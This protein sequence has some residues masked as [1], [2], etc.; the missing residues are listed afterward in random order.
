MDFMAKKKN[1]SK[2]NSDADE[3]WIEKGE[4]KGSRG[5]RATM[6]MIK[7]GPCTTKLRCVVLGMK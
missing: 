3:Q 2:N 4:W 6:K 1:V 5:K 7:N